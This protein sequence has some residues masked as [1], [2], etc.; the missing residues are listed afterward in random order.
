[1]K[2]LLDS[3]QVETAPARVNLAERYRVL[4]GS[5]AEDDLV[6]QHLAL[7]KTIVGRIALTLPPHVEAEDLNSAGMIGLLNAVRQYDSQG[8]STFE[9]YAS[10]RIRGAILDELRRL[11]WVPRSIHQ[12]ARKVREAIGKLE[13]DKGELPAP[14]EVAR[15]L[16]ISVADYEQLLEEIKPATFVCLDAAHDGGE[17]GTRY[18]AVPDPSQADPGEAAARNELSALVLQRL[19]QLPEIQRKVL[20]LYYFEDLRLREIAQ[21]FGLTESR[22]CQIHAQAILAIKSYVR[23]RDDCVG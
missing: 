6:R 12:K 18:E 5:P 14:E 10:V 22:I 1:M 13:Q 2:T 9:S 19:Q 4:P 3:P 11:D 8:G 16:G 21:V 17:D 7:V 23:R 15:Y 20:A